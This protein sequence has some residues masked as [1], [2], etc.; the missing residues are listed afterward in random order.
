METL[1]N[2]NFFSH[3][4]NNNIT[5]IQEVY[6]HFIKDLFSFCRSQRDNLLI[7]FTLNYTYI[8]SLS[9]QKRIIECKLEKK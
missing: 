1:L 7:Y 3:V 4:E 8:E 6:N 2:T 9:I 5:N